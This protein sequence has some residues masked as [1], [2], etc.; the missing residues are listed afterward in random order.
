MSE[1]IRFYF[2]GAMQTV[3]DQPTT[4]TLL[5]YVREQRHCSGTKE[6]CAEGDCGACTVV[7]A[8]LHG[9]RL[10]MNAVNS[11]IQF[12]PTLDG[13]AVFTVED[14]RQSNGDLHPVQQALVDCHASQCGFCTP[15]FAMS[16]WSLYLKKETQTS[17]PSREEVNEA[18][19]GNLCR[20]T[21]YRPII[22]AARRM[23]ELPAVHFDSHTLAAALSKLQRE[24]GFQ[25]SAQGQQFYAPRTMSEL[26]QLRA[27]YPDATLLSG[28]TD[29]GLWVTKQMR[30]LGDMIYLGE[31]D[32]LRQIER[33]DSHLSI[34]AA[35]SLNDA[36]AVI[37][38]HYAVELHK[39]WQRFASH[40]IRN[41]GT[42][43]GN[44]ANGSPIGDSAPW[45]I[46]LGAEIVLRSQTQD[47]QVLL[48]SFYLDYMKK[49]LHAD[50]IIASIRIPLPKA[51]VQFRC[52][53]LSKRVDQDISA[54]CGAFSITL[55][56]DL[57]RDARI[58]FGGMAA[59]TRRA[60]RT[61]AAMVGQRWNEETQKQASSCLAQD[62][63][64]LTD[65]RASSE[66]RLQAA[67]NLLRRFWLETGTDTPSGPSS[68]STYQSA[69]RSLQG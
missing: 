5:Q 32:E 42:L 50:E 53:K 40:S 51:G 29:I 4:R 49:D 58:V 13:K 67:Q 55:E 57:I 23:K 28:S 43:G 45:L 24:E 54:V 47:R 31:V 66:Y 6:A 37:C 62:Y 26:L 25:Y 15:G 18:L 61:E 63:Q 14:L 39:L 9:D 36:Y 33:T 1:A 59:T 7:V 30:H 35:V 11:C 60:P 27:Q 20:C 12:M 44:V 65:M 46:A 68:I 22:D 64:P 52:Y 10:E 38:Q 48:E 17:A 3:S 56:D 34:G 8:Q 21:G 41:T 69:L 16:L 19:S 2:Q